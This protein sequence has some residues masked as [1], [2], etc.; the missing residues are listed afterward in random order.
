[1]PDYKYY[2]NQPERIVE[3]NKNYYDAHRDQICQ[4]MSQR[5][6]CACGCDVAY[7]SLY[8][9]RKTKRHLKNLEKIQC[10]IQ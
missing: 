10:P 7:G 9:H 2:R 5:V 1:M 4:Y 8:S 6:E 3:I